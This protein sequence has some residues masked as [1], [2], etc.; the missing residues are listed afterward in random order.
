MKLAE[1][2]AERADTTRRVEQLRSRIVG[3]ARFQE[4]ETPP[5]DAAQLLTEAGEALDRLETLIR[6]INRTNSAAVMGPDGTVTDALARRDVLRLRHAVVTA[7]ADAAAGND[8]REYGRQLRS[9]LVILPALPVAEL[10]AQADVLAREIRELDMRIQRTN[11]EV[12]LL[13]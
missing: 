12:D 9:E 3:N 8:Q 2:L 7:A 1:A 4:G 11:W 13:D 6:R 5:E 10:R